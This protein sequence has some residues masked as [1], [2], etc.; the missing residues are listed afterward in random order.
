M[1][2]LRVGV[3]TAVL[4]AAFGTTAM[5]QF[6]EGQKSGS[7]P[8]ASNALVT[9]LLPSVVGIDV[10]HNF[11]LSPGAAG[12]G[13]WGTGAA[14]PM[15]PG[16]GDTTFTFAVNTASIASSADVACPSAG[17][18]AADKATIR[19]FSSSAST[20]TLKCQ[21]S[22]GGFGTSASTKL[23][24]L[25]PNIFSKLSLIDSGDGD[26]CGG[27]TKAF[28]VSLAAA[29]VNYNLVTVIPATLFSSCRQ[30]LQLILNTDTTAYKGG[31]ATAKLAY[32]ITTP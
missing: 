15:A 28:P 8:Q 17:A 7:T 30:K 21:I 1:R 16:A 26:L 23:S 3:A 6:P 9:I 5:A 20:S 11:V 32:T 10:E 19:V 29:A 14:F 2:K 22:D 4:A 24:D 25:V 31:A 18:G 12:S 13:C 27:G